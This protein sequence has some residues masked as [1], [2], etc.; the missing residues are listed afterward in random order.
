MKELLKLALPVVLGTEETG[1]VARCNRNPN[2]TERLNFPQSLKNHLRLHLR[3]NSASLQSTIHP[4]HP[5][6]IVDR[7]NKKNCPVLALHYR[8]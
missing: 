7:K 8:I 5:T 6:T 2:L 4:F 1:V 3:T